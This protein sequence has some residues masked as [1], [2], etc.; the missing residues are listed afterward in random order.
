[1]AALAS[2]QR[3]DVAVAQSAAFA[4]GKPQ[5]TMT[6]WG[7]VAGSRPARSRKALNMAV[8]W[9]WPIAMKPILPLTGSG[10]P[11]AFRGWIFWVAASPKAS[12]AGGRVSLPSGYR[13]PPVS[14]Y[15]LPT[16]SLRAVV[17][18]VV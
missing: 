17:L 2:L 11:E 7:L 10:W 14:M 8:A 12:K 15:P 13:P 3:G 5:L 18:K 6:N 9:E 1:M 16:V 4:P